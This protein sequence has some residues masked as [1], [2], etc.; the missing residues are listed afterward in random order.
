MRKFLTIGLVL[1]LFLL[2]FGSMA[3]SHV[4]RG[5]TAHEDVVLEM[6]ANMTSS[7]SNKSN[8]FEVDGIQFETILSERV[9]TIPVKQQN[10][11][12]PVRFGIRVTNLSSKSY[13]FFVFYLLPE[14]QAADGKEIQFHY[15]RNATRIPEE[16][17]DFPLVN[18]GENFTFFLN[19]NLYWEDSKLL[20]GGRDRTGGVWIFSNLKLGTY[21]MRF[22]YQNQEARVKLRVGG[23]IVEDIWTG[24]VSMPFV[25]F[26][27]IQS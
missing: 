12:T 23:I 24:T 14:L 22:T 17:S 10:A 13:R 6:V 15:G 16:E 7:E 9:L 8:V 21:Q 27:L 1:A 25:N 19:G 4:P 26:R 3:L 20:L 5:L 18:P 2:F 11:R